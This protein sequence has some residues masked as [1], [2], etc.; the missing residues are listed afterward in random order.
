MPKRVDLLLCKFITY[1]QSWFTQEALAYSDNSILYFIDFDKI[2]LKHKPDHIKGLPRVIYY[3]SPK[4]QKFYSLTF[5]FFWA[6]MH[7]LIISILFLYITLRFRPKTVWT[8]NTWVGGLWSILKILIGFDCFIYDSR[9]WIATDS[10]KS[11]FSYFANNV[12]WPRVDY[13]ATVT[14][15]L[16]I[17]I[18]E[19]V[20]LMRNQFWKKE[21]SQNLVLYG[22]P[23][24]IKIAKEATDR[25]KNNICYVGQIREDTG[26]EL[27]I[28]L[29]PKLYETHGIKLKIL[30]PATLHHKEPHKNKIMH[31]VS[32]GGFGNYVQFYDWIDSEEEFHNTIKDCFCGI[33]LFT[34]STSYHSMAIP[35]KIS[36]YLQMVIP[37]L[38]TH[39]NGDFTEVIKKYDLG[40]VINPDR[41]EIMDPILNLYNKQQY[42]SKNIRN[43]AEKFTQKTVTE[44]INLAFKKTT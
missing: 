2:I 5:P 33:S 31:L 13:L 8:D 25:H 42:F 26:L 23:L 39:G 1:D 40:Y 7:I 34:S 24:P 9:D 4:N 36:V 22:Y 18:T 19:R 14:S 28:P 11:F 29:M 17:N 21:V 37:L 15:D 38:V 41:N 35:G 12:V 27:L 30:G 20:R 10:K 43:Y 44:Y 6:P 16:Q 32:S 3:P